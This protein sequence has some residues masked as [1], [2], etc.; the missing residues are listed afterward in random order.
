[1][2]LKSNI[3]KI[4]VHSEEWHSGRLAKFT[5]SEM[6]NLMGEKFFTTGAKS[7]IY[8]KVGEEMTGIPCRDEVDTPATRH[9]LI[10]ENEAIRKYGQSVGLEFVIVQKLI[11]SPDGRC[12]CTPDFLIVH[13][14]SEDKLSY[15]VSTGEV[16]CPPTFDAYISLFMCDSPEDVLAYSKAYFWQVIDQMDNCDALRGYLVVYHPDFR[17]GNMKVIEFRKIN[18][19]KYFVLLKERKAMAI[20]KFE[21]VRNCLINHK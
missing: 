20:Q 17:A 19:V 15:N 16:K 18:L 13:N 5:A 21:E 7:Y 12:G 14:E 1:M 11:F 2:L 9:G 4:E 8:R 10:H 6:H 3:S